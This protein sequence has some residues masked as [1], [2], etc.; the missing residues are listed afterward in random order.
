[1]RRRVGSIAGLVVEGVVV[2][3]AVDLNEVAQLPILP[4]GMQDQHRG[5]HR[6]SGWERSPS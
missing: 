5:H 2:D 4:C 1:M 6:N 3:A